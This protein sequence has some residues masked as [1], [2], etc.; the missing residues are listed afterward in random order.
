MKIALK[1]KTRAE[2]EPVINGQVVHF[3]DHKKK[4]SY[5][6]ITLGSA[7]IGFA[8]VGSFLLGGS[9]A[10]ARKYV[11][12]EPESGSR[13][14]NASVKTDAT[15]A[16]SSAISFDAPSVAVC[17]AGQTGTPPNC[18]T[19]PADSGVIS[20]WGTPFFRDEFS[21]SSIDTSRWGVY[22]NNY[23]SANNELECNTPNNVAQASG[24]LTITGKKQTY[25]C[26]QGGTKNYTSAFL[27]SRDASTARYYP[28][29]GRFEMRARVPHGQGLWPAFWLRHK[30]GSSAAEVDI[31]ELFHNQSPGKV[32][33]TLHFP[34]SIGSNVSKKST[35]F[36]TAVQGTGG[37]H[38]FAVEIVPA[39]GG[40]VKFT[41]YV[42]GT[43]TL[44][45]TNTN[46]SS[47]TTGYESGAWDIA[48]NM[49]IGGNWVGSPDAQLGYL[50]YPNKCSLS[51]ATPTSNDPTTC[52]TA[53]IWLAN[54][55][56]RDAVYQIDYV[57]MWTY[58]N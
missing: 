43:Q 46:A 28:L 8:V 13:T 4:G 58:P 36:E 53:G 17:P 19:P 44:T 20:F 42:D 11:T 10:A 5:H 40:A 22:H 6:Y 37:W 56:S 48:L 50:P 41:F 16:N 49:A 1:R 12:T 32:T 55:A 24:L 2:S 25:A 23:G 21:A 14:G 26:P 18:I 9:F 51:Y 35:A 47:W 57:R 29:Y 52:S 15:A 27:G 7:I 38:T 54:M 39:S 31:V 45:Y 34:N 33:S 3:I 30:A